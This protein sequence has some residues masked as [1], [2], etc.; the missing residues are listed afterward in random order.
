MVPAYNSAV[1]EQGASATFG[2][3]S[4]LKNFGMAHHQQEN[5]GTQTKEGED[6]EKKTRRIASK[7]H[8]MASKKQLDPA[9]RGNVIYNLECIP[10]LFA[11]LS[12]PVCR[13]YRTMKLVLLSNFS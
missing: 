7:L 13:M 1:T 6:V 10:S 9:V 4:P 11:A 2:A 8:I 12:F 3:S 5:A